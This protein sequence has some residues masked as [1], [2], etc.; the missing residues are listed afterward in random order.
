MSFLRKGK[1]NPPWSERNLHALALADNVLPPS[2]SAEDVLRMRFLLNSLG[3]GDIMRAADLSEAV[4]EAFIHKRQVRK[5]HREET[6]QLLND[7][8]GAKAAYEDVGVITI[9]IRPEYN[10]GKTTRGEENISVLLPPQFRYNPEVKALIKTFRT[11]LAQIIRPHLTSFPAR[12]QFSDEFKNFWHMDLTDKRS[13]IR[14]SFPNGRLLLDLPNLADSTPDEEFDETSSPVKGDVPLP[15]DVAP[16][17]TPVVPPVATAPSTP[18]REARGVAQPRHQ[19]PVPPSSVPSVSSSS[20]SIPRTP[21]SPRVRDV[22]DI[23]R[24]H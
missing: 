16:V 23:A 15:A 13:K 2:V 3:M 22:M 1:K 20:S 8:V 7:I 18:R 9:T 12:A 21:Q 4:H 24:N 11:D 17:P 5:W 6:D 14:T 10:P 19:S